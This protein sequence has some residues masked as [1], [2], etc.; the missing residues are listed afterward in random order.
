[1]KALGIS[2]SNLETVD[3]MQILFVQDYAR[4]CRGHILGYSVEVMESHNFRDL[5]GLVV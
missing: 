3:E 5:K 2:P 1:M 4:H